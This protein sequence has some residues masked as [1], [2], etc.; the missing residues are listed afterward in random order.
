MRKI[1]FI[2]FLFFSVMSFTFSSFAGVASGSNAMRVPRASWSNASHAWE[3]FKDSFDQLNDVD[4]ISDRASGLPTFDN[5]VNYSG[6]RV[7]VYYEDVLKKRHW[8]WSD[9]GS[10]GWYNIVKPDDYARIVNVVIRLSR[11]AIPQA[12]KYTMKVRN[13]VQ[14]GGSNYI[15]K[16]F[17]Y[18][19]K[20]VSN[21]T[22]FYQ[23]INLSGQSNYSEY[24]IE[25]SVNLP[26]SYS[27][28]NVTADYDGD[29]SFGFPFNGAVKIQFVSLDNSAS[30]SVNPTA[31]NLI[32]AYVRNIADSLSG[33]AL[34]SD[35]EDTE[36][37]QEEDIQIL[38]DDV[39]PYTDLPLPDHDV[40]LVS[41]SF[42]GDQYT[43]VV[44]ADSYK[45]LW[46]GDDRV[47]YNISGS[48]VTCRMFQGGTFDPSSYN[49]TN[50][51]LQP[52]L[53]NSA[54]TVYNNRY[55]SYKTY[56]YQTS[57]NWGNQLTS[58]TTYGNF[59]VDENGVSNQRSLGINYRS[60]YLLA[61][62][63]FLQ[64]VNLLC[65]WKNL[66]H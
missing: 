50:L 9:V 57:N 8:A 16:Y 47:L 27:Y 44:P 26:T 39:V 22:A 32:L 37:D 38:S 49:Y 13:S 23:N 43:V 20:S 62:L 66:R 60:Y 28:M 35:Q 12:G 15:T 33:P 17:F 48:S 29:H 41:G 5:T 51:T 40:V 3:D 7:G 56:Y 52:I 54:S 18:V 55:L 53:G 24:Y 25:D 65:Y 64:G 36:A 59:Y 34:A 6:V 1:S 45:Y 30:T 4:L 31:G 58:S 10:D 61:V 46:I 19:E 21:A 14:G 42:G 2:F 63:I 11:S